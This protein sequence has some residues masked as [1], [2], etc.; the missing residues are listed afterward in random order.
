MFDF[1]IVKVSKSLLSSHLPPA[2]NVKR[3]WARSQKTNTKPT[4]THPN[5]EVGLQQHP[6]PPSTPQQLMMS[7]SVQ[8][9]AADSNHNNH[10]ETNETVFHLWV[11]LWTCVWMC[12][13]DR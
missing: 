12:V 8:R 2:F 7:D 4:R 11:F 3:G 5:Y 6:Q 13:T 1:Q 9:N 10:C